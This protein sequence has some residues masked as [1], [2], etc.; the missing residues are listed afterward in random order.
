MDSC[1]NKQ[2][3]CV[4]P[5]AMYQYYVVCSS[6]CWRSHLQNPMVGIDC[7]W[8]AIADYIHACECVACT[9]ACVHAF[10]ISSDV[11]VLIS[12]SRLFCVAIP[13]SSNR[14]LFVSRIIQATLCRFVSASRL[15][16]SEIRCSLGPLRDCSGSRVTATSTHS[17]PTMFVLFPIRE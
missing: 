13:M 16:P 2:V 15:E 8:G 10:M 7:M 6:V 12:V 14:C 5:I 1:E 4:E 17:S 9:R 11:Y 3:L